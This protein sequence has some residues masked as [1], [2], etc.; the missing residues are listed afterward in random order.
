MASL[1]WKGL[2]TAK[3]PGKEPTFR[4]YYIAT[5]TIVEVNEIVLRRVIKHLTVCRGMQTGHVLDHSGD[6]CRKN[7]KRSSRDRIATTV[8]FFMS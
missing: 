2:R 8:E 7:G 3:G 5:N 1:G 6:V 4:F